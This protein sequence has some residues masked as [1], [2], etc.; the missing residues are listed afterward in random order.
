MTRALVTGA[1]GFIGSYVADAL[2]ERGIDVYGV[3]DLSGGYLRN[4][5][6]SCHFIQGDLRDRATAAAIIEDIRPELIY[7]LAADATEGRSQFT[8]IECTQRNYTAYLHTLVPAIRSQAL[9]KVILVSSM[10]VYGKQQPP[11]DEEMPRAPEDI[12]AVAKTAMERA[13]EI[14][15]EVHGF[16]YTIIRPYNVYGP[17]QNMQDPYRNVVGIFINSLLSGQPPHIYGDGEQRRA[18]GYVGD[19]APAIVDAGFNAHC[20]GEIVNIGSE[21]NCTINQLVEI[22]LKIFFEGHEIP[23]HVLPVYLPDRPREVKEAFC[24]VEKARRFLGYEQRVRLHDG[25]RQMIAWARQLGPQELKYLPDGLELVN[26]RT[27][28]PWLK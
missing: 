10:S 7:H 17:R 19:I 4:V 25:L 6:P 15:S 5:N 28:A 22:I 11:F 27:P 13:T 26:A 9:R 24:S 18:F 2:A 16:A 12:Y 20:D 1:A 8:P 21:S 14:L 23:A 3:D